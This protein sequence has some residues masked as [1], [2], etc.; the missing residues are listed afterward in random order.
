MRNLVLRA[1]LCSAAAWSLRHIPLSVACSHFANAGRS[2]RTAWWPKPKIAKRTR[3]C[4]MTDLQFGWVLVSVVFEDLF[5]EE[6]LNLR[7]VV[8][9]LQISRLQQLRPATLQLLPDR[10]LH[11][12]IVQIALSWRIAR[13]Q[14]VD[15]ISHRLLCL[16]IDDRE[17]FS[18][19]ARPSTL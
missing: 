18:D 2:R 3:Y 10:L 15:R 4:V 9:H 5:G 11:A 6:V 14:L 13:E 12:R 7:L 1:V 17:N 19:L 16:R 8:H